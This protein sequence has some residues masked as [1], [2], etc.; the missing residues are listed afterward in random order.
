MQSIVMESRSVTA[1]VQEMGREGEL[2]SQSQEEIT[3]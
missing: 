1:S 2:K 3:G